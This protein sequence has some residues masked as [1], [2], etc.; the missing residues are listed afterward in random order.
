MDPITLLL[1]A[2]GA[3]GLT[4]LAKGGKFQISSA[5]G[6]APN[7]G[8]MTPPVPPKPQL[9]PQQIADR[10]AAARAKLAAEAQAATQA[11]KQLQQQELS[12]I[13][14]IPVLGQVASVGAWVSDA[15][16][17]GGRTVNPIDEL[18]PYN[19][20][21]GPDS[22]FKDVSAFS[23]DFSRTIHQMFTDAFVKAYQHAVSV[24]A[25]LSPIQQYFLDHKGALPP[26]AGSIAPGHL[27][28]P[29]VT[30]AA[31]NLGAS[32]GTFIQNLVEQAAR[33]AAA[34]T[35]NSADSIPPQTASVPP[36]SPITGAAGGG[37]SLT[38]TYLQ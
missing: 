8:S 14:G 35:P 19:T 17:L 6:L 10:D 9:T 36:I 37:A 29:V 27:I 16:N 1:L 20:I 25:Q 22:P 18:D 3:L 12:G 11:E 28:D 23:D 15:F 38:Q 5:G 34:G 32:T 24:G 33:A 21:W 30:A 2:G 31:T 13:K 26:P 4:T 7:P